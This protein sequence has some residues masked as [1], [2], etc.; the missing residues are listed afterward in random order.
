MD[1]DEVMD[2]YN[3]YSPALDGFLEKMPSL[4]KKMKKQIY[5]YMVKYEQVPNEKEFSSIWKFVK[6]LASFNK[7]AT[8][9]RKTIASILVTIGE[10]GTPST[11]D[12]SLLRDPNNIPDDYDPD[13]DVASIQASVLPPVVLTRSDYS[14]AAEIESEPESAI[15]EFFSRFWPEPFSF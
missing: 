13:K 1:P 10:Q 2:A 9:N 15:R 12:C 11:F 5:Q 6:F 8:A 14:L 7:N 3:I 4:V